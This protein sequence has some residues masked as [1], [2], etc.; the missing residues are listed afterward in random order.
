MVDIKEIEQLIIDSL[1]VNEKRLNNTPLN[2]VDIR[3]WVSPIRYGWANRICFTGDE[4]RGETIQAVVDF[5]SK[6]KVVLSK[7]HQNSS[8]DGTCLNRNWSI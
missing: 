4:C 3:G 7:S 2:I 8:Q 6:K 5:F 1:F